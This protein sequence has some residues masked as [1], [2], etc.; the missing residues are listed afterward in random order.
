MKH[1]LD[2]YLFVEIVLSKLDYCETVCYCEILG[3]DS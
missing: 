1:F 3:Q 2:Y